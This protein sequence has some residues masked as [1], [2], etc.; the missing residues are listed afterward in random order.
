[1]QQSSQQ[2]QP[3]FTFESGHVVMF[4]QESTGLPTVRDANVNDRD[5]MFDLLAEQKYLTNEYN[6]AM[7]EASSDRLFQMHKRNH[8]GCHQSQRQLFNTA[9]KKGWYRLPVADAQMFVSAFEH[10]QQ[11]TAEWPYPAGQM[12]TDIS[13]VSTQTWGTIDTGFVPKGTTH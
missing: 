11:A 2:P 12:G 8:E 7:L 10:M 13:T 3:Q 6:I 1:M 4:H 5:R 9:F